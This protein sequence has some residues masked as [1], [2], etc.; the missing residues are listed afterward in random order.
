MGLES[1]TVE[2]RLGKGA[3]ATVYKVKRKSDNAVYAM[4][5][6]SIKKMSKKEVADALNEIRLLA[7]VRHP[8]IVGFLEAFLEGEDY[9]CIIMEFCA[10]GDLSA[11]IE[12]YR[13]RRSYIDER[14]IWVYLIQMLEAMKCLHERNIMHRD[15]K[16]A[17]VFLAEDGSV[18]IGDM[19][20]SKVMKEGMLKTQIGTPYYM[21]P[22]IWRNQQYDDR[23]DI[24]SLGCMI[25]ELAALRPPFLGDS[26][27]EL[28]R[29]VLAGRYTPIPHV[30]SSELATVIASMVNL[31]ATSRP[32][33][34]EL[35]A[36]PQVEKRKGLVRNLVPEDID[37]QQVEMLNTIKVPSRM[38][39]VNL[40]AAL[41][42]P[43]YAD[44]R[45]NS[46]R[47]WPVLVEEREKRMTEIKLSTELSGSDARSVNS[48]SESTST[49]NSKG[50]RASTEEA[51][52]GSL[53][54][55]GGSK[56]VVGEPNKVQVKSRR[57]SVKEIIQEKLGLASNE[58]KIVPTNNSSNEAR[59]GSVEK[60]KRGSISKILNAA[61]SEVKQEELV[62]K[63]KK[64]ELSPNN[65]GVR[66][67]S[68][69]D[70][71][72]NPKPSSRRGS[73]E[74]KA[75]RRPSIGKMF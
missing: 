16:N 9:L 40:Q 6:V 8:H 14:V 39:A 20:V 33:A 67:K 23:S 11:K 60:Q 10:F 71:Y 22:E 32:N 4:K 47:S 75:N 37:N 2:G 3:F 55:G 74:E 62:S 24:W 1:F 51:R 58:N 29:N 28:K 59:R 19:N 41:P 53:V 68:I 44:E 49:S 42:K 34:E 25:Y 70:I 48:T 15:L 66:R 57:P 64:N 50:R 27:P 43:C 63:M 45:P 30:Y 54:S 69:E 7:S 46:P 17:N 13:K 12:R 5:K 26:F 21:S 18:K 73:V 31:S 65:A 61:A 35:L 38:S 56:Y 36:N 72:G 52:R